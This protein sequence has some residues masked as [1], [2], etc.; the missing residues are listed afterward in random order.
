MPF[1]NEQSNKKE[2]KNEMCERERERERIRWKGGK[3]N[4]N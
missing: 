4:E 1:W 3:K 2:K